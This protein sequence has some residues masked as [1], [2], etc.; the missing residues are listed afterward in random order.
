MSAMLSTLDPGQILLATVLL[1]PVLLLVI[2]LVPGMADRIFGLAPIAALPAIPAALWALFFPDS[3][4]GAIE[5]NVSAL[6][7][8]ARFAL[9]LGNAPWLFF[10]ALLWC[11]A[12]W[13]GRYYLA[14]DE[15]RGRYGGFFLGAM[16]G[17]FGLILA[18]DPAMFFTC[19]A[20]MSFMSYGLVIHDGRPASMVAGRV[21]L[22]MAVLGEVLQFAG[23]VLAIFPNLGTS[24]LENFQTLE[25][26]RASDPWVAG[27]FIAGFGVKAGLLG[28]HVW[29]P[30]AHPVAPTPASAVLSG[31]MIKAGLIGWMHLLPLGLD[32]F[33]VLGGLMITLGLAGA[34]LAA[35]IGCLQTHPKAVLAYSSVSQMG[36]MTTGIGIALTAPYL[37]TALIPAIV[38]YASHHAFA[39][40]LLFLSVGLKSVRNLTGWERVV[41]WSGNSFAALALIGAPFTSGA[42]AKAALKDAV[43]RAGLPSEATII[44]L[45]TFA[46]AGTTLL[47][48]RYLFTLRTIAYDEHH[49]SPVGVWQPWLV[50]LT[51]IIVGPLIVALG[52]FDHAHLGSLPFAALK[53]VIPMVIGAAGYGLVRRWLN[54][55]TPIIPAGDLYRLYAATGRVIGAAFRPRT[56]TGAAAATSGIADGF[57]R[58]M[59]P[60]S[61]ALAQGEQAL[62][63]WSISGLAAG[64]VALILFWLAQ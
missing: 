7:L 30:M 13:F 49:A 64:A 16:A 22:G 32:A 56:Q 47:M 60:V 19:F 45:L 40:C 8:G 15:R 62:S 35:V 21:Y 6:V 11:C 17:N 18:R 23:L 26:F 12:G 39:K 53:G 48:L 5:L 51:G 46:A 61:R 24:G 43:G 58:F 1:L 44:T 59:Q 37:V 50:L 63:V 20:V 36:L 57:R 27:L 25:H 41:F 28:L 33:P 52:V 10:T 55:E 34:Y 29:L 9:D 38:L 54:G 14:H 42:L 2:A 4:F 31:A 3:P